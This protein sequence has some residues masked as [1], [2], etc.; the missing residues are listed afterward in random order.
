MWEGDLHEI[1]EGTMIAILATNK[2]NDH[3]FWFAKVTK[4]FKQHNVLNGVEVYQYHTIIKDSLKE[5]Y[6]LNMV[7]SSKKGKRD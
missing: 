5:K 3:P 7:K 2:E 6:D 1:K 4:V